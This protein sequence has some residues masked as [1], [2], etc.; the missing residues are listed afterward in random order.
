MSYK[1]CPFKFVIDWM[2]KLSKKTLLA[3]GSPKSH[4]ITTR[5]HSGKNCLTEYHICATLTFM[6]VYLVIAWMW[7]RIC[8]ASSLVGVIIKA[9]RANDRTSVHLF[10]S[11]FSISET[12]YT[13]SQI[14]LLFKLSFNLQKVHSC[15]NYLLQHKHF[16]SAFTSIDTT[17]KTEY[18]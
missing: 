8:I 12:N 10:V 6:L 14:K 13:W 2:A 7:L 15:F 3:T 18:T 17:K 11:V 5:A 9:C 1:I 4:K 16:P